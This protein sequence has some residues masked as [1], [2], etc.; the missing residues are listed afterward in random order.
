M[1]DE[2][3]VEFLLGNKYP[4]WQV[5]QTQLDNQFFLGKNFS[6][7]E[8]LLASMELLLEFKPKGERLKSH[9]NYKQYE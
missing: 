7:S 8:Y 1:F 5:Q 9:S 6:N 2:N 4:A 3:V